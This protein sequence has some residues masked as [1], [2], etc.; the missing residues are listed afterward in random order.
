MKPPGVP[1]KRTPL[2]RT[3]LKS[4]GKRHPM[5]EGR[6]DEVLRRD[7]GRCQASL[8]GFAHRCEGPLEVHHKRNR[9][10]GGSADPE[11]HALDNLLTLCRFAHRWVT[12]HPREAKE[13]GLSA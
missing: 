9:G 1:K 6:Y 10:M 2:K 7:Q 13:L 11:I 4:K 3:P 12:E 8:Y 5:P